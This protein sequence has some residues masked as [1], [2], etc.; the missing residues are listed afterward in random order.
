MRLGTLTQV[1]DDRWAIHFTRT[2]E[3]PIE[4]VWRAIT[5][6]EHLA[7]WFPSSVDGDR[8]AGAPLEFRFD[9][10]TVLD[11]EMIAFEPPHLMEMRWGDD[12][13]RF[14]LRSEGSRTVLE[15]TDTTPEQGKTARDAAGWH[16]KLDQ[17]I[18]HVDGNS[19]EEQLVAWRRLNPQYQAEFG[20]EAST[21]GPPEGHPAN[22]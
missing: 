13:L 21:I 14:E 20:P 22:G 6:P 3:H 17:L 10:E 12:V 7:A 4:K 5:E 2:L 19:P 11:G 1:G 18:H 8:R 15:L 16:E 9:E